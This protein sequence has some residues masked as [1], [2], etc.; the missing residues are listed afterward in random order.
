MLAH[1]KRIFAGSPA[2][3]QSHVRESEQLGIAI[4]GLLQ[5]MTRV[6][7]R[8]TPGELQAA[9]EALAGI[10]ALSESEARS[11]MGRAIDHR[12]TSYFGPVSIIKRL[13]SSSQ[14][15]HLVEKF[16]EMAFA[17]GALDPYEDH[18]VRKIAH[19]LYV[20]NTEVMLARQR[21][22]QRAEQHV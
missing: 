11:I 4:A 16:W 14:R 8:V 17:D 20:P 10:L 9:A 6:D 15:A 1:L 2:E 12:F 19:L 3:M 13:L 22:R 5:E 7:L 21:A 18:F